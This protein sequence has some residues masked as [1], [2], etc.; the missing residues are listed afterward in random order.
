[1]KRLRRWNN[2][3]IRFFQAGEY[4]SDYRPHHHALLFGYDFIDGDLVSSQGG[5]KLYTSPE[6]SRLW[7]KG[8]V[9]V[10]EATFESAGYIARYTMKKAGDAFYAAP[11]C[12]ENDDRTDP[13]GRVPEYLTMSRRPGIGAGWF[14]KFGSE[15]YPWDEIVTSTGKVWKPPRFYDGL[16]ERMDREALVKIKRRRDAHINPLERTGDRLDAKEGCLRLRV[17]RERNRSR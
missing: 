2:G 13:K 11:R 4:G 9:S 16:L 6:L 8:F 3:G 17:T 5:K 1:M 10:G 12:L 14:E 7:G 15:V